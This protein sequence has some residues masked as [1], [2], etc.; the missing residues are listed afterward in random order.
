[1]NRKSSWFVG[2]VCG[3]ALAL[4]LTLGG[5]AIGADQGQ[6]AVSMEQQILNAKTKADHEALAAQ[7][8]QEA[9]ALQAQADEHKAMAKAYSQNPALEAKRGLVTHCNRLAEKYAEAAKEDIALAKLHHQLAEK[10]K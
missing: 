7:F 8:E 4:G 5:Y 3:A 10:A 9:K 1:M 2:A 6:E